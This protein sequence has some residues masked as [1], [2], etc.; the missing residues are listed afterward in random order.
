MRKRL[1]NSRN[2]RFLRFFDQRNL[3]SLPRVLICSI[4]LI[5][6]FY[7]MPQIIDFTKNE[8][9]EYQ[10]NSKTI[11]AYTL[12]NKI[13]NQEDDQ[14]LNENDLL[15][16]K[17]SI[18]EKFNYFKNEILQYK[19]NDFELTTSWITATH[20]YNY[21]NYHNH[22]NTMYTGVLYFDQQ[23]NQGGISFMDFTPRHYEIN[24]EENNIYNSKEWIVEPA[25]WQIMFFPSSVYHRIMENMCPVSRYSLAFCFHPVGDIGSGDSHIKFKKVE[26]DINSEKC[27]IIED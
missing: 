16:L 11:L 17:L 5:S 23:P 12:N 19:G 2:I 9:V 4:I 6:F 27:V 8:N 20:R 1:Y 15:P 22:S 18:I 7:S 21:S 24:V 10:N 3:G 26:G 14:V 13:I 25:P